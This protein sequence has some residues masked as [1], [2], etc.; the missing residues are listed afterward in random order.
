[1]KGKFLITG[2]AAVALAASTGFA[3]NTFQGL[4]IYATGPSPQLDN[5]NP[6][7]TASLMMKDDG[8]NG[9]ATAGDGIFTLDYA[10]AAVGA[11]PGAI[12]DWKV[13]SGS[14]N[15]WSIS[16]P[17]GNCGAQFTTGVVTK[18]LVDT[19]SHGDGFLPDPNGSTSLG[20][21]YT[22]P[23]P[24]ANLTTLTVAGDFVDSLPG[25]SEWA[26]DS[27]AGQMFDDGSHGDATSGDG[28]YTMSFTGVPAGA[29]NFKITVNGSFDHAIGTEGFFSGGNIPLTVVASTDNIKIELNSNTGRYRITNDNASA[30][31]GP[32]FFATSGGWSTSLDATTQLYDD[33]THGDVNSGDGIY[34]RAFVANTSGTVQ[35]KQNVGSFYPDSGGVPFEIAAPGQTVL[36]QFDTNVYS[37]GFEPSTRF[38][39]T[40]PA[41]RHPFTTAA[42]VQVVGDFMV[43]L[44]GTS[45]WNN[46][47]SNFWL[48]DD[49]TNGD[50]TSADQIWTTNFGGSPGLT[51]KQAK[52]VETGAWT[53]QLGGYG[54]GITQSGDNTPIRFT[55]PSGNDLIFKVDSA[56]G[57]IGVGTGNPSRPATLNQAASAGIETWSMY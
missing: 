57:R 33:A 4:N 16:I 25:G 40:D 50:V 30:S 34:A 1:M 18:L 48:H 10:P 35:V 3:Q 14:P 49:G 37:D 7:G 2:L 17:G 5:W 13:G 28:I 15:L 36:V 24:L 53:L 47:D 38:V 44:S 51:Y 23:S 29:Y 6:G 21:A 46:S 8:T 19:S 31:A 32:P 55:V 41:S 42:P 45:D 12:T 22:Q 39:W 43:S 27:A 26:A 9:D 20:F 54:E 11:A 52:A 56:T